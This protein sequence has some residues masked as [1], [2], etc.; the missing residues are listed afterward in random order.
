[1]KNKSNF[2]FLMYWFSRCPNNL[3]HQASPDALLCH[4]IGSLANTVM[5]MANAVV[6]QTEGQ[7]NQSSA[8]LQEILKAAANSRGEWHLPLNDQELQSMQQVTLRCLYHGLMLA[9]YMHM[10]I[11]S[12]LPCLYQRQHS[13]VACMHKSTS[14]MM[15]QHLMAATTG[16][17][18][19]M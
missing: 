6:K 14:C 16:C 19:Y 4:R 15:H 17:Q 2:S 3:P 11:V 10:L 13:H 1:M 18:T 5:A 8:V 7:L 12:K 9:W